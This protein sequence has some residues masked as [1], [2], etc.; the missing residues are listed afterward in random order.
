[1][2]IYK[3]QESGASWDI[4][5]TDPSPLD[6]KKNRAYG[7]LRDVKQKIDLSE[8]LT[9]DHIQ[10][11]RESVIFVRDRCKSKKR[12]N[13]CRHFPF[14]K[15]RKIE[16]CSKRILNTLNKMSQNDPYE[17]F[18]VPQCVI[19]IIKTGSDTTTNPRSTWIF[20]DEKSKTFSNNYN[21]FD[22]ITISLEVDVEKNG[23]RF[24]RQS[25]QL[26]LLPVHDLKF[27][28][29]HAKTIMRRFQEGEVQW[30]EIKAD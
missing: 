20:Y 14:T 13:L 11:I 18:R 5:T 4:V 6:P 25:E 15:A 9:D 7:F 26:I 16:K 29:K 1:M 19:D 2:T 30:Q 24:R 10:T 22:K 8:S 3:V 27:L 12:Y 28:R 23:I 21:S 17:F